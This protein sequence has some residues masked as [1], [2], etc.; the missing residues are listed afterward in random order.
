MSRYNL[1]TQKDEAWN[2][3]NYLVIV[4]FKLIVFLAL[5]VSPQNHLLSILMPPLSTINLYKYRIEPVSVKL[6]YSK[7]F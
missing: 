6:V 1:A 5:T 4:I 3:I 7:I 2:K